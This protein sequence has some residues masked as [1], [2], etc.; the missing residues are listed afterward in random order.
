MSTLELWASRPSEQAIQLYPWQETAVEGLRAAIREGKKNQ[1]LA[2]PTGS[3]KTVI[4]AFLIHE[5]FRLGKRAVFVCDRIP[6]I[7]QTS[8]TF[9]QYGIPHGVIQGDHERVQPWQ[10]IQ[11]ASAQTLQRRRWPDADLIIV[12]EA[13]SR[14]G[15]VWKRL[16][17]RTAIA[18]GLTATPFTKGLGRIYDGVVTVRTTRQ[19]IADGYLADFDIWSASEPDMKGAKVVGGEW[20]DEERLQRSMP[21][22]GDIVQEYLRH[23]QGGKFIAF[24]VNVPHCE[25]IQRQFLAAGVPCGLY[26]YKTTDI[27][28]AW[29]AEDFRSPTGALKGLVSVAALSKGF[30]VPAVEVVILARPLRTSLAEHIQMLGRGLRKD[31][32]NPGKRCVVL[33][34]AGNCR[35]FWADMND[36]LGEGAGEL[37]DGRR[38]EKKK[39][40]KKEREPMK[41]PRCAHV[42]DPKPRCPMCGHEYPRRSE[43]EHV[44][45]TLSALTGH[46][47][48]SRDDRQS[49]YSQLL[50]YCDSRG[51]SEGAGAHKYRERYG[52]WPNGLSKVRE[53]VS[54]KTAD[55]IKSRMIAW[56]KRKKEAE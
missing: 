27:E 56:A 53:P 45:G 35:R 13:H 34:H 16:Q 38:K 50:A 26:T 3:G 23:G 8:R 22:V 11:I 24:G 54:R 36:F 44:P 25:E 42:H 33:D 39:A 5:C 47:A 28:R 51:W 18:I 31:P 21:I 4:G 55:W 48:G 37:D 9:D 46:A 14:H 43:V 40:E 7:E 1:I 20:T 49:F 30:D 15:V 52:T 2:A 32:D 10:K 19:L 12:D 41:C 29:M 6:L 17:E